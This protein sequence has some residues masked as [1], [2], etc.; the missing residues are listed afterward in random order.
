M[1]DSFWN[2]H[3][4]TFKEQGPSDF[5][6]FCL[7]RH[8]KDTDVLV[9][10]GC[11]NGR[12]GLT[13]SGRVERYVGIDLCGSAIQSFREAA[14][15]QTTGWRDHL[16]LLQADFTWLDFNKFG[17]GSSRLAL[18]NRFSLHSIT[19]DEQ[20]RLVENIARID[21]TPW[22]WMIEARTVHDA[23]YGAGQNVGPHE[24]QTDHYRRF[25]DPAAFLK[26]VAARFTVRYFEVADG[27]AIFGK[28]NPVVMRAVLEGRP[29]R[30]VGRHE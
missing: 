21:A 16:E 11:G 1:Q 7:V 28:E 10:L 27:F 29:G 22:I 5:A 13:L 8:L 18:F 4:Q 12:D 19:Y 20:A 15:R 24:F 2:R 3:Y 14:G 17:Q 30:P 6:R 9:D 25:I 26:E 23:L